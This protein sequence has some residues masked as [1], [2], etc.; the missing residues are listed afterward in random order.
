ME[1]L[2]TWV[3]AG[4]LAYICMV[5][6]SIDNKIDA[7]NMQ[8]TQ[9]TMLNEVKPQSYSAEEV[10]QVVYQEAIPSH[11]TPMQAGFLIAA[12][13]SIFVSWHV[14]RIYHTHQWTK[15]ILQK[16]FAHFREP[17]FI[18]EPGEPLHVDQDCVVD[19]PRPDGRIKDSWLPPHAR[20]L[21]AAWGG[22]TI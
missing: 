2:A 10:Q 3:L 20:K 14:S 22:R 7:L 12:I 6:T 8:N 11:A 9:Y 5:L 19:A 1:R 21:Y 16:S 4:L 17:H 13:L 15:R 18:P